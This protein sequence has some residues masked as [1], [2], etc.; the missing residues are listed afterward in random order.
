MY[1]D[2]P[3]RLITLPIS[4][5]CSIMVYVRTKRIGWIHWA[6]WAHRLCIRISNIN[7]VI[8]QYDADGVGTDDIIRT[9]KRQHDRVV[10]RSRD[11]SISS[12]SSGSRES[13][14]HGVIDTKHLWSYHSCKF[15]L[16]IAMCAVAHRGMQVDRWMIAAVHMAAHPCR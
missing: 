11:G 13:S 4:T 3:V 5:M 12:S 6:W 1:R 2:R 8:C 16:L 9:E 15:W 14:V 7:P 10:N